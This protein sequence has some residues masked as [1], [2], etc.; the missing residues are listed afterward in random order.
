MSFWALESWICL[1]LNVFNSAF[2]SLLSFSYFSSQ[3]STLRLF[4]C[5][6]SIIVFMFFILDLIALQAHTSMAYLDNDEANN[7]VET[8]KATSVMVCWLSEHP[9]S[10]N[11]T[12]HHKTKTQQ[13]NFR[14]S[15]NQIQNVP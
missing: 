10:H 14:L 7:Y 5:K 3:D 13:G 12:T 11:N 4:D 2:R 8:M 6:R 1:S 15:R 9:S